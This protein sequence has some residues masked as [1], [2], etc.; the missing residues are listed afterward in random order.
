MQ[1][2]R[3][4]ANNW[5]ISLRSPCVKAWAVFIST[6]IQD[7]INIPW[8]TGTKTNKIKL[9]LLIWMNVKN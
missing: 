9:R 3:K 4:P 6:F 1:T 2:L 5:S 7:E 8:E